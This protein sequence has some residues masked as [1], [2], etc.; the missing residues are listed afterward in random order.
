METVSGSG[1]LNV[2]TLPGSMITDDI[3]V[4]LTLAFPNDNVESTITHDAF[5]TPK[6]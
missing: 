1:R 2:L 6:S 4:K 3:S 5:G